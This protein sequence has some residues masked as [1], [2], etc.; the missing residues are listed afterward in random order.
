MNKKWIMMKG[1]NVPTHIKKKFHSFSFSYFTQ[2][3]WLTQMFLGRTTREC[4]NAL[5]FVVSLSLPNSS[6][7]IKLTSN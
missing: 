6:G 1:I 2:E 3:G 4:G 5:G 7:E